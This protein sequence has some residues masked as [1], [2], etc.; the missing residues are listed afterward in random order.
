MIE[1]TE[2]D[3]QKQLAGQATRGPLTF[4]GKTLAPCASGL[5]DLFFKVIR[6]DD[7]GKFFDACLVFIL[8][9]AYS[10]TKEAA[11][12]KRKALMIATDDIQAFRAKVSLEF[13]DPLDDAGIAELRTVANDVVS[14]W[15]IAKVEVGA[16]KKDEHAPEELSAPAPNPTTTPS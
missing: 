12:E 4:Q 7:T 1:L 10:E 5:R 14:L 6:S 3:I 13:Q 16:K 11:L 15:Q 8:L 9:E 2:E